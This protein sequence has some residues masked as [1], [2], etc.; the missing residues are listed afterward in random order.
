MALAQDAPPAA[1][2]SAESTQT[3][4]PGTTEPAPAASVRTPVPTASSTPA[5]TASPSVSSTPFST[6]AQP[7][8]FPSPVE[9]ASGAATPTATPGSPG[10]NLAPKRGTHPKRP[11]G[12][13]GTGVI[14]DQGCPDGKRSKK[15]KKVVDKGSRS[16]STTAS[17]CALPNS[18]GP[19]GVLPTKDK[20]R[21]TE[22]PDG[23]PTPTNPG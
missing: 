20:P 6:P 4:T 11:N 7:T 23:T 3:P 8:P 17:E 22:R 18:K 10:P 19:T 16:T 2:S 9:T 13:A 5:Q 12:N 14:V 21:A 15:G 1:T